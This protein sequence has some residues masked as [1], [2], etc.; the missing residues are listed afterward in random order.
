MSI[1]SNALVLTGA[2]LCFSAFSNTD[3]HTEF[4]QTYHAYQ[5]AVENNEYEKIAQLAKLAYEQGKVV[6]GEKSQ[7][8]ANLAIN[9]ARALSNND[10]QQ[11][12]TVLND[13]IDVLTALQGKH[14]PELV[15]PYLLKVDLLLPNKDLTAREY[16]G[17]AIDIAQHHSNHLLE[18]KIYFEAAKL[19]S[20]ARDYSRVKSYL[21]R[22]DD[23][24]QKYLPR[25]AVHRLTV[26]LWVA[27]L[28]SA[29]KQHKEA[30]AKLNDLIVVFDEQLDFDHP[31][32]LTAHSRLVG[33]YEKMGMSEQA[34]KHCVMIAKMTPWRDDIEQTPLYRKEPEYPQS[35]LRARAQGW[36]ALEFTITPEGF[37]EDI[38][39]LDK[40][41][42]Q[43]FVKNTI[44]ALKQWRYAPKF[45]DGK[46]VSAKSTVRMDFKLSR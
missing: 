14:S 46:A 32:E 25:D 10:R 39:V 45:E 19:F 4:S 21:S 2:L 40:Q 23:I 11:A 26:D 29:R 8:A 1:T 42:G 33:L 16:V 20:R 27:E 35:A 3:A 18:S 9:Y 6:F 13:A 43:L 5:R 24:N 31:I 34:T 38:S 41:H 44:N 36:V 7:N 37:V 15:D 28:L 22:A 12:L 30:I 17:F